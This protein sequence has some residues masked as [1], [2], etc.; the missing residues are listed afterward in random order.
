[1]S[2][3]T[4]FPLWRVQGLVVQP[5]MAS[6]KIPGT[7]QKCAIIIF[8]SLLITT[9]FGGYL[10]ANCPTPATIAPCV[11]LFQDKYRDANDLA[12]NAISCLGDRDLNLNYIFSALSKELD[13]QDKNYAAFMLNNTVIENGAKSLQRIN[14]DAFGPQS[15]LKTRFLYILNTP[16]INDP[17]YDITPRSNKKCQGR[18]R[19][20][21]YSPYIFPDFLHP[22]LHNKI[23]CF[24]A[25]PSMIC[26][27]L[28]H[29]LKPVGMDS[30]PFILRNSTSQ[31]CTDYK[32]LETIASWF[33][34]LKHRVSYLM[35]STYLNPIAPGGKVVLDVSV[36]GTTEQVSSRADKSGLNVSLDGRGG[37]G[38]SDLSRE[39]L[40]VALFDGT[41]GVFAAVLNLV[42]VGD[43]SS[44]VQVE[45]VN[46]GV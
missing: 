4:S 12:G 43:Q 42:E 9:L 10:S 5:V 13:G 35:I 17:E 26:M 1:M 45:T 30:Q 14:V 15:K 21:H 44:Q 39:L 25:I 28:A 8:S 41:G 38:N 7:L 16:I 37:A 24:H 31:Q 2:I 18:N 46:N 29:A 6:C 40:F 23:H 34:G 32:E 33:G 27:H 20:L 22:V 3:V 36:D 11:C 19:C